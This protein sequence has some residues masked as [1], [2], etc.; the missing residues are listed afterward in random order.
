MGLPRWSSVLLIMEE[1]NMVWLQWVN[2]LWSK[3]KTIV[4]VFL[5]LLVDDQKRNAIHWLL[6][7]GHCLCNKFF[8]NM[9]KRLRIESLLL[10]CNIC[11]CQ[12]ERKTE[13][14]K[15]RVNGLMCIY[16]A[17]SYR[18][19]YFCFQNLSKSW[20]HLKT[21]LNVSYMNMCFA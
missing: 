10:I 18:F 6:L 3:R 8:L 7:L 13:K 2:F 4:M 17:A 11:R 15:R 16:L 19:S 21:F 14:K 1:K 9:R 12:T 5:F 20:I